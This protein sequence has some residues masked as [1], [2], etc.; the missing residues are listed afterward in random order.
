MCRAAPAQ[1]QTTVVGSTAAGKNGIESVAEGQSVEAGRRRDGGSRDLAPE[2]GYTV[3]VLEH[4]A[5]HPEQRLAEET[6]RDA[7]RDLIVAGWT[8]SFA[9]DFPRR[10]SKEGVRGGLPVAKPGRAREAV[11]HR[12]LIGM[13][14][15]IDAERIVVGNPA[16]TK[17]APD[18]RR[19]DV[20]V[21]ASAGPGSVAIDEK[22]ESKDLECR[23]PVTLLRAE[24]LRR[25]R[26]GGSRHAIDL[27]RLRIRR[28]G[29]TQRSAAPV[30]RPLQTWRQ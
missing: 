5:R 30:R 26:G 3:A 25:C 7:T 27:F 22:V 15:L 10:A 21:A 24:F 23:D 28:F 18:R 9:G 13:R 14:K 29:Q 20:V 17:V 2:T 6:S 8:C 4:Q 11:V 1:L 19:G 12:T 16:A